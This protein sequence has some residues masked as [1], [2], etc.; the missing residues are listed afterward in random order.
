MQ[1]SH[2]PSWQVQLA[3]GE[4]NAVNVESV[5]GVLYLEL[6]DAAVI[7][8]AAQLDEIVSIGLTRIR[9][10]RISAD[11]LVL[12]GA[13]G[14]YFDIEQLTANDLVVRGRS[15]SAFRVAGRVAHQLVDLDGPTRYRAQRLTSAVSHVSLR[16]GGDA[17]VRVNEL[18][19]V[20]VGAGTTL[21]YVG[22][23]QV[24]QS[25]A[26]PDLERPTRHVG[27]TPVALSSK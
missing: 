27:L 5:D 4:P 15:H 7:V 9:A 22:T 21:R 1:A 23:P 17:A 2:Q 11:Q 24:S 20:D 25:V 14:S 13:H 18:L 26:P 3:A 8:H 19:D 6:S 16:D 12:E 10:S